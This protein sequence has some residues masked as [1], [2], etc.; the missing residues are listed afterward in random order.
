MLVA[1]PAGAAWCVLD[2]A[3]RAGYGGALGPTMAD[4]ALGAALGLAVGY[5]VGGGTAW[6]ILA[7]GPDTPDGVGAALIGIAVGGVALT[8]TSA[9]VAARRVHRHG[10]PEVAPVA[11]RA[12]DGT[13]APGLALRLRL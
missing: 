4:A 10:T 11:L 8:A 9:Y 5:A 2:H 1:M 3:R 6:L 12:P 13:T 7:A